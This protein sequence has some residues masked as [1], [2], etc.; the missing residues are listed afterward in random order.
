[1]RSP[2]MPITPKAITSMFDQI[3]AEQPDLQL[4]T[5]ETGE[6]YAK[7]QGSARGLTIASDVGFR[8]PSV[9]LAEGTARWP[10]PTSTGSTTPPRCSGCCS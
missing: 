7:L 3:A 10:R 6:A 5:E 1:M 9:W 4:P 8:M 2:L